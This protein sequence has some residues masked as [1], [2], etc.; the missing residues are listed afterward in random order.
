MRTAREVRVAVSFGSFVK[1]YYLDLVVDGG[2]VYELKTASR[3]TLQHHGQLMNY[4]LM[5]NLRHGE[6]INLCSSSV[7]SRFVNSS[8]SL[9][10]RRRFN[11][12]TQR[13]KGCS[14]LMQSIVEMI[15]D[16]GVGLEVPLYHQAITHL[17]G[18]EA[19]ATRQLQL[20]RGGTD[21]GSQRFHLMDEHSAFRVTAYEQPSHAKA[22]DI[23]RL[24][25][26]SRLRQ[27]HW[28]NISRSQVLFTSLL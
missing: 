26:Y 2:G 20:N 1:H 13:W 12:V 27:M 5:L 16:W 19:L 14:Q 24:V 9:S 15:Q 3:L 17:L 23:V 11:V 8:M 6:L 28:I 21:L 25:Q 22:S 18:G 7:E 10:E 4:L